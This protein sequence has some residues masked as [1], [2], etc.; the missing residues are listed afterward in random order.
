MKDVKYSLVE[1]NLSL[2]SSQP[3][4]MQHELKSGVLY[5]LA[6]ILLGQ[7]DL[8]S[9]SICYEAEFNLDFEH[10]LAPPDRL[11]EFADVSVII[12]FS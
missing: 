11:G 5:N 7:E 1:L 9:V 8:F 4:E 6:L 2:R 12:V 10:I 3:V